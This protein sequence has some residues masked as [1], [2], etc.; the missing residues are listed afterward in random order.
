[1]RERAAGV[2]TLAVLVRIQPGSDVGVDAANSSASVDHLG[3]QA[4]AAA[5]PRA[6]HRRAFSDE[7]A[8]TLETHAP[9]LVLDQLLPDARPGPEVERPRLASLMAAARDPGGTPLDA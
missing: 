2:G 4:R 7:S 8:P 9:V 1:M 6:G 5:G 3:I